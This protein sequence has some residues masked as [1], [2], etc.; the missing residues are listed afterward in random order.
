MQYN[1]W[2]MNFK[3]ES[4]NCSDPL[5]VERYCLQCVARGGGK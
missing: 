1:R 2:G 5:L 4:F 3:V